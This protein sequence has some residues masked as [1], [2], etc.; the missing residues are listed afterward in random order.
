MTQKLTFE[1][2]SISRKATRYF[3]LLLL[4]A[5][6]AVPGLM[7]LQFRSLALG[8]SLLTMVMSGTLLL[9]LYWR[10]QGT[11]LVTEKRELQQQAFRL[12]E[13][14]TMVEKSLTEAKQRREHLLRKEQLGLEAT[15][16]NQQI[17]HI[18][19]GLSS[20]I[21]KDES[22]SGV[23]PELK[24]LLAEAGIMTGLD[25]SDETISQILGFDAAKREVL[26]NW[27]SLL[28]AQLD[29]TKP[30]KLPDYQLEY[31]QKKFDRLHA[32]ND[33]KEQAITN[34]QQQFNA[35]LDVIQQRL[36]QLATITFWG[37]LRYA[38]S[39]R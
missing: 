21:I 5:I 35:E 34:T 10:Y 1:P 11:P 39:L 9:W 4:G 28:H 33:E 31:I 14:I 36:D 18:Q 7:A 15:L 2:D 6:I 37:Y 17:Y 29:A 8:V 24:E 26:M 32:R 30:G 12:R 23:G 27:R 38:L 22:I 16:L 19:K 13:K 3:L 20:Y 25:V